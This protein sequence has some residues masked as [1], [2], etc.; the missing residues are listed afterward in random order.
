M[1]DETPEAEQPLP[2]DL[3]ALTRLAAGNALR[4][5]LKNTAGLGPISDAAADFCYGHFEADAS[6]I[7]LLKGDWFRTLV[8]VGDPVPGQISHPDGDT[9]GVE[10]Y[11]TLTARL[12]SG[13]GYVSSIGNDGGVP[14]SA[15]FLPRYRMVTCMG[16]PISYGG[17]VV[18]EVFVSR[19]AGRPHYS[20]HDLAALLDLA[21]QIGYRVGPAVKAQDALDTSWWPADQPAAAADASEAEEPPL[22]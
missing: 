8:T 19:I 16:A 6:A 15:A 7:S 1:T 11:P 18:G 13:S 20:G 2:S 5:R 12:R 4:E 9:Y 3:P 10:H 21:R 22:A 14:E 17:D